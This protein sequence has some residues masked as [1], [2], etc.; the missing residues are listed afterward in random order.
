MFRSFFSACSGPAYFAHPYPSWESGTNEHTNGLPR[1]YLPKGSDLT[2]GTP[3]QLR[4]D[5]YP[6]NHRPRK[7]LD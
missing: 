3:E 5:V 1:Q 6:L 4:A 7:C 2:Q